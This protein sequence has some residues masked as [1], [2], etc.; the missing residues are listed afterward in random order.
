MADYRIE[1][2]PIL[3]IPPDDFVEFT[4]QGQ[5]LTARRGEMIASALFAHGIHMFG[6]H[7]RDG[8]PQG[9]FCANGQCSQCLVIADGLPVKACMTPV[10]PGMVVE[11]LEGLPVLPPV[12]E[13]PPL[14][15]LETV[16]MPVL[17]IGG[18]PAGMSA[19]IQLAEYGVRV[20]LVDD[21]DRLGGKLVLQTHRFFGSVDAVYAGTRGIDIAT[22]LENDVRRHDNIEVWLNSTAL[23]VFSDGKVG[24]LR[25]AN[26]E[27][28]NQRMSEYVLVH[29]EILLVAA[30]AREKSLTFKGNTLPGVYGAGAF[31]TLVNRDLVR[32]AERL[33]IVGGGNV[34]L[35]AGYHAL[36]AGIEVVGLVEAL[37]ECGGYK[38]HRDK[39]ARFGVPIYTSHTILSANGDDHVES[40]TIARVD[41]RFRPIPGT[42]QSFVCD[43]VLI[44]VGLDPVNEFTQKAREFGMTVFDAGDAEAIA[45]ASAA[46]FS[47]KIRGLEIARALGATE[48]AVPDEWRRT[49]DILKSHPGAVIPERIPAQEEGVF[50]VFHCSQAIPCNPCTSVCPQQLIHID[51]TDIRAVPTYLG[52]E[53]EKACLGCEQ[54]VA[55][56]PGLAITLVDYRKDAEMPTVTLAYEFLASRIAVGDRVTALDS[57]ANELGDAEVVSVR[58]IK[59]NDRTVMV[60]VRAPKAIAKLVAGLRVQPLEV[61]SALSDE[62]VNLDD[63]MI[64]CRCERVTAGEIRALIRKGYR[65]INEIKAVTRA[66]MGACGGK[67]CAALTLRL[68]REEGIPLDAV[69]PNIPRPLFVEVPLGVFAANQRMSESANQRMDGSANH[70]SRITHHEPLTPYSLLP[71]PSADVIIIGAGS[72]GVPAALAMARKGLKVRVFDGAASQGQGSNKAAIGGV[73]AT[74]SDPAKIRLCLRSLEIFSTWEETYGHNIEW[75]TGGYAFV[76]YREQEAQTFKEL[77]KV[78]LAYGLDIDWYDRDDFLRIV[79][80]VNPNSLIGGT[81]SPQDGHCS[82]LLAGHAFYDAAKAAGAVFHFN[83]P[84]MEILVDETMTGRQIR[85]I[86]TSQG[87]YHAPVVV[88]A[89]GPWAR[90]VGHLV[91]ME[92]PVQP[93]SHEAGITEPVAHFLGPMLVDIRPAPGSA[94]YYFFQLHSGQVVFCIT[95]QPSIVGFDR[96]ETSVFLPQIASRMVDLVPRLANLRVRRTWRGLYPMTPD[97]SPLVGWAREVGGYLMAIGMCGQGFMLGPGLGELLAR[98]V[99]QEE[100]SPGD[101]EVLKVLSPY[102]AFAGQE[103]L[104]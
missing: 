24:I 99:A 60:K 78:Q 40:V 39:L 83:E 11:P 38:V 75:T 28:A 93:D 50:P 92:H 22:R 25:G 57:V 13:P 95:P 80:D 6:H 46:M 45:E 20:L 18:G 89:A 82:T 79:P 10:T 32:A 68:F 3:P 52:L 19:A 42:E 88:N 34:G 48:D 31:Q 21:K 54:C 27:S 74:H 30:G 58:A 97:G 61:G 47:G 96:R 87:T 12:A 26:Q 56:C 67:T 103:A 72:V 53:A 63:D 29:P 41:E 73:R 35:I 81:F 43:T 102:R 9:I 104:K 5:P 44:A 62:V 65:D 69:T 91:G 98:T 77:L 33:F 70:A 71:T 2:H 4:W 15:A 36:Q 76:A 7:H 59:R 17:I 49:G 85:G 101:R 100:L 84:V 94:N 55:V 37:P 86:R 51:P 16:D 66:G 90:A 1:A 14:H 64:V 8:S 23:A